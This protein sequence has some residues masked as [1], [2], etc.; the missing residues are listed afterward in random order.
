MA[1]GYSLIQGG[2]VGVGGC[3]YIASEFQW[4]SP[5]T[6]CKVEFFHWREMISITCQTH[7]SDTDHPP[8]RLDEMTEKAAFKGERTEIIHAPITRL[9]ACTEMT[10]AAGNLNAK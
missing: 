3:I 1:T 6:Q 7:V 5:L 9:L 2:G 4:N 10:Q 8:F